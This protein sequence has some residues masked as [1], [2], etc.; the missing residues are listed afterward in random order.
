M[1]PEPSLIETTDSRASTKV[2]P[3]VQCKLW[4]I[5]S[6]VLRDESPHTTVDPISGRGP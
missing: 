3:N 1:L 6:R 4:K 5:Q 2:R